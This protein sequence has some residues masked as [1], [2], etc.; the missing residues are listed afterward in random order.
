MPNVKSNSS[1]KLPSPQEAR[2][3]I[4][5]EIQA[6]QQA[7][8][9]FLTGLTPEQAAKPV[10]GPWSAIDALI[11]IN[12]WAENSL[13]VAYLQAQADEPDPGPNRGAAGY[14]HINVEQFNAEVLETHRG[15][16][17]EQALE[18]SERVNNELCVALT[19]LPMERFLGGSGR[20][21][22]R[23]WYWRPV[24]I[25]SRGHRQRVMRLLPG[26]SD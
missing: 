26:K 16:T 17:R 9:Q 25:H 6:Q 4:L 8:N 21:G 3:L 15:W 2:A 12:A 11:H 24:V 1:E 5:A 7:W 13:R 18:W 22:A 10:D 23:M 14:L 20:Y 19:H